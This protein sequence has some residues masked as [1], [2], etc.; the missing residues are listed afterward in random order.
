M[1]NPGDIIFADFDG[2]VVIPSQIADEV[3]EKALEKV[4][5]ENSMK[6]ELEEGKLLTDLYKKYGVL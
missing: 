6:K 4:N 1:V 3:I 2:V 5:K